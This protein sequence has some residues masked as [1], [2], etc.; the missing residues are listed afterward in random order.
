MREPKPHQPRVEQT[1]QKELIDPLRLSDIEGGV[2]GATERKT[3]VRL[4]QV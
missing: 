1:N 2:W 3:Y 4:G